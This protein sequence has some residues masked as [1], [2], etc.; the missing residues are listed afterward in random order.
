MGDLITTDEE[1]AVPKP[2]ETAAQRMTVFLL[3]DERV[4]VESFLLILLYMSGD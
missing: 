1:T 4:D 2:K 3:G